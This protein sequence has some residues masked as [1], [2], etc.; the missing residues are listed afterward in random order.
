MS[1][2]NVLFIFKTMYG[3]LGALLTH[4]SDY[5]IENIYFSGYVLQSLSLVQSCPPPPPK[6]K[7]IQW[8]HEGYLSEIVSDKFYLSM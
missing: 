4:L 3:L 1:V 7:R 5:L 2:L 6:K 8:H